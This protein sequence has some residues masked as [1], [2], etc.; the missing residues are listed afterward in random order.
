MHA[1][2]YTRPSMTDLVTQRLSIQ[3]LLD[4]GSPADAMEAY[5]ALHHDQ[6][7]T[8]LF[9][10]SEQGKHP[11][12]F[13]V[14]AQ[15]GADLFRPLVT[16]RARSDNGASALFKAGLI[17]G[18]QYYVVVPYQFGEIAF[19]E[20]QVSD[21]Q[22]LR[23]YRLD[24]K[25][26]KPII[27]VLVKAYQNPNQ[28][29]CHEISSQGHIHAMAGINW[30]SPRFA[31][32]YVV[33]DSAAR[34]RGWGRSVVSAL[35]GELCASRIEPLYV[36]SEDNDASLNLAQSVGFVDTGVRRFAGFALWPG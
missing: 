21:P 19:R 9:L 4:E 15:T 26:Y 16:L 22:V 14:R 3:N 36:V 13:L 32:V 7:R 8:K 1:S 20:L 5:Y 27:N 2:C 33:V 35:V 6:D 25:R 23:V 31:E 10:H 11:D 28:L 17:P 12:G 29:P 30:R 18:R 24:P 34:G